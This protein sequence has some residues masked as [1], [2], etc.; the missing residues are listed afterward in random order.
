MASKTDIWNLALSHIGDGDDVDQEDELS[1]EGEQCRK[2]YPIARDMVLERHNWDF[3]EKT[4][5]LATLSETASRQWTYRYSV[6]SDYIKAV[7]VAPDLNVLTATWLTEEQYRRQVEVWAKQFEIEA[8][9]TGAYSILT[10][11]YQAYL[12]YVYRNENTASYSAGF[13]MSLSYLLASFLAGGP[14]VQS[15]KMAASMLQA[16][17]YHLGQARVNISN[18]SSNQPPHMP[19]HLR[20][21]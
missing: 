9:A 6:P 4:T 17:E 10:N 7:T 12:K 14:I 21:R 2:F 8:D 3:A 5:Q 11:E 13:I 15:A 16:Y 18:A 1:V 20:G 19:A